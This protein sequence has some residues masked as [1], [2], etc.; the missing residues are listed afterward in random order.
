MATVTADSKSRSPAEVSADKKLDEKNTEG[1][2]AK[3]A[4]VLKK[5][6]KP[7]ED[8]YKA[9]VEKIQAKIDAVHAK[10]EEVQ[11]SI[12]G[13]NRE[14]SSQEQRLRKAKRKVSV[15]KKK[16]EKIT[17]E[18]ADLEK[19]L[20]T[21][22]QELDKKNR[23]NAK[24]EDE[25]QDALRSKVSISSAGRVIDARIRDLDRLQSTTSMSLTEEKN[26]VKEIKGLRNLKRKLGDMK[27][28]S[29]RKEEDESR[30]I[31]KRVQYLTNEIRKCSSRTNIAQ[32]DLDDVEAKYNE[33]RDAGMGELEVKLK[34][35]KKQKKDISKEKQKRGDLFYNQKRAYFQYVDKLRKKRD[36]EQRT[37]REKAKKDYAEKLRKWEEEE[38]KRKPWTDEIAEIDVL[39]SYLKKL[40]PK[41]ATQQSTK[42]SAPSGEI[43]LS[44]GTV[45][46]AMGKKANS[47]ESWHV[48]RKKKKRNR[49]RSLED[50]ALKHGLDAIAKFKKYDI[51]APKFV[52]EVEMSVK[53]ANAKRDYYDTLPRPVKK[54]EAPKKEQKKSTKKQTVAKKDESDPSSSKKKSGDDDAAAPQEVEEKKTEEEEEISPP[55]SKE[56]PASTPAAAEVNPDYVCYD[57]DDALGKN[58]PSLSALEMVQGSFVVD[59]VVGKKPLVVL[60][61]A[62]FLKDNCYPA[63]RSLEA[64]HKSATDVHILGVATDPKKSSVE[65]HV[66][67]GA[68]PTTFPLAFDEGNAVKK[69]FAALCGGELLVPQ[70]FLISGEGKIVWRQPFSKGYPYEKSNFEDQVQKLCCGKAL[71]KNGARPEEEDEEDEDEDAGDD[72]EQQVDLVD[73]L[74]ADVDW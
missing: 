30:L 65:R 15:L 3:D 47:S 10:I 67:K 21:I 63:M 51:P 52:N 60:F 6:D 7:S 28:V 23:H 71:E 73:P 58:V 1:D 69:A 26:L 29:T 59:D 56:E 62:K 4:V 38:A 17:E 48:G 34:E 19:K 37:E 11:K 44:D 14:L 74:A 35:L 66:E 24:I 18:V 12:A 41:K 53:A 42:S 70:T 49:K 31:R 27:M 72:G 64:L 68:C 5:V 36:A 16:P 55:A 57:D 40:L 2:A 20:A 8:E 9:D 61:W 39:L 25:I 54:K 13:K 22:G 32:K 45:V 43:K 33:A 50:R 46:K